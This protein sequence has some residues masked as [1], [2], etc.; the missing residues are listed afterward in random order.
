MLT[1]IG[2]SLDDTVAAERPITVEDLLSFRLGFGTSIEPRLGRARA[3]DPAGRA[4]ARVD[5]ARARRGRRRSIDDDE[6]IR[7]FATLPLMAQPGAEW[8]YN[9][10]LQVPGSCW[11]GPPGKPLPELLDERV[12]RPLGMVDTGFHVP[13]C[14]DRTVDDGVRPDRRT[15]LDVLDPA[16]CDEL[17]GDAAGDEQR[18]RLVGRRRSTTCGRSSG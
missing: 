3:A 14:V 10:G 12:C 1:S 16:R 2:A 18:R 11:S 13:P 15:A 4:R 6:W 17:V 8:M 7:R 5:D 9:T